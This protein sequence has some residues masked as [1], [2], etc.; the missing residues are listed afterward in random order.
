MKEGG[1]A[2]LKEL[3]DFRRELESAPE[4]PKEERLVEDKGE[5]IGILK[6]SILAYLK[7][8]YS[9]QAAAE[10]LSEKFPVYGITEGDVRKLLP[11]VAKK[12]RKPAA[13]QNSQNNNNEG[14][15]NQSNESKES[16]GGEGGGSGK[17]Y[18]LKKMISGHDDPGRQWEG[19]VTQDGTIAR[20]RVDLNV[21][22][23]DKDEAKLLG[24][25]WDEQGKKWYVP[26]GAWLAPFSKW[27]P[28]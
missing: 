6:K 14:Q 28:K 27:M 21:G 19:A 15:N 16:G 18:P 4:L 26:K 11:K 7:K 8:G 12:K 5:I 17:A 25:R 20:E 23:E 10:K 13:S 2:R 1:M 22:F 9:V 24:A 3:E